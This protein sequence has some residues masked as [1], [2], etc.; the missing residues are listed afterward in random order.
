M[1]R[2]TFF[3]ILLFAACSPVQTTQTPSVLPNL[4]SSDSSEPVQATFYLVDL[5]GKGTTGK[6]I[7]CGDKLVQVK[8]TISPAD[9]SESSMI[10]GTL[11]ELFSLKQ[12]DLDELKLYSAF[13]QS[14]LKLIGV[15]V[16]GTTATI[17]MT[18]T[19]Q[20]GGVCDAP[21]FKGQIEETVRMFSGIKKIKVVLNGTEDTYHAIGNNM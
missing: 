13:M 3:V 17:R 8:R 6:E 15:S 2:F 16:D 4:P 19:V 20:L 10:A 18:G 14:R 12:S 1:K 7:G 11:N 9:A 21:R 5:G